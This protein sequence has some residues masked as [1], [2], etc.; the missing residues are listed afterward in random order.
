MLDSILIVAFAFILGA[1]LG[2]F[3]N[4][5]VIRLHEM[6][7]LLGRSR[8]PSCK[9]TL[10]PRH[11]VPILSWLLLRGRCADCKAKIHF[12]YPVVEAVA[13]VLTAIAAVR[14]DPFGPAWPQFALEMTVAIGL[15]VIVTMDLRWKE[16]PL[17]LMAML[18]VFGL[19]ANVAI[20]V[21]FSSGAILHRGIS[22]A[23]AVGI[24]IAFFG[25][26]WVV[27]RGK[28]LGSGDVWFGAMMGLILGTWQLTTV[29]IYLA[30]V[31]GGFVVAVFMLFG[32]IKRGM[33]VP[34]APALAVGLLLAMWFGAAI[35]A[36]VSYVLSS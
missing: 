2:S 12:Q 14:H 20:A 30:Y 36:H 10:R 8:C 23:T 22:V 33:R 21:P 26:Q 35:Q 24:A 34:F 25:L 32:K 29:G 7:S 15:I 1:C 28:W 19:I 18:G 9:K 4:V 16:L 6:S 17:E 13:A 3:A 5:L 31:V 11:L 27:S